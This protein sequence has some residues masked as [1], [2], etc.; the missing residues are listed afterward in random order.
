M[1]AAGVAL[2]IALGDISER[3][4]DDVPA[5]LGEELGGHCLEAATEE[6]VQKQCLDDV[7]TVVAE[8]DL[9]DAVLG[10]EPV[11]RAAAQARAQAAEG[12]TFGDDAFDDAVRV[13]L[14]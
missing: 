8:G 6:E 10:G 2:D 9:G 5:I 1:A 14:D 11:K 4:N 7:V 13:L 12:P 3:A